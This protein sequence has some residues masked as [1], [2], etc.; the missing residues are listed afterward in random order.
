ME[1]QERCARLLLLKVVSVEILTYVLH[2]L[3]LLYVT[4]RYQDCANKTFLLSFGV[5]VGTTYPSSCEK[6]YCAYVRMTTDI[7]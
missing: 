7:A 3:V 5:R 4:L 6:N 1:S 2:D